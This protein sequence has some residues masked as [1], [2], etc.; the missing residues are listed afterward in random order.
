MLEGVIVEK[1]EGANWC[2]IVVEAK[3]LRYTVQLGGNSGGVKSQNGEV[4]TVGNRVRITY[5][6]KRKE[7]DGSYFLDASR[8]VQIRSRASGSHLNQRTNK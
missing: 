6:T 5:R 8:V 7:N 2:G 1:V 4:E 3:G